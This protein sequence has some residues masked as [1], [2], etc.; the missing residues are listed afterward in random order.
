MND[1]YTDEYL[2]LL[3]A[4][5]VNGDDRLSDV[6]LQTRGENM[7][8]TFEQELRPRFKAALA[9]SLATGDTMVSLKCDFLNLLNRSFRAVDAPTLA[10]FFN[11][12]QQDAGDVTLYALEANESLP[13]LEHPAKT[14]LIVSLRS[15]RIEQIR[16]LHQDWMHY[17]QRIKY[18]YVPPALRPAL[19]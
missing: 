5:Y 11:A 10:D 14:Q 8:A 13:L 2:K 16:Q 3:D 7:R 6:E 18:V 19:N 15:V 1:P 12:L 17:G 4:D 9:H